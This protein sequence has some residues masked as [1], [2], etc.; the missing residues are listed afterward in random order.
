LILGYIFFPLAYIMGVTTSTQETLRVAQLMG[1]K[2][3]LNEFI[4]FQKLGQMVKDQLLSVNFG[5]QE[6]ISTLFAFSLSQP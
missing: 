6:K 5:I 1:T 3:A 2:T 4:A